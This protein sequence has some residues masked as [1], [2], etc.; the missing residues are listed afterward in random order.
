M[1]RTSFILKTKVIDFIVKDNE[2]QG[3]V[4]QNGDSIFANKLIL[5]TGHSA[6]QDI[7]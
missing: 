7:F 2:I 3:V 5:A 6:S 1:W 4:T